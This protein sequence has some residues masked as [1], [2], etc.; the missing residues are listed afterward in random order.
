MKEGCK[1]NEPSAAGDTPDERPAFPFVVQG[2]AVGG[3]SGMTLRE[4]LAGMALASIG[5]GPGADLKYYAKHC[6][7]MADAMLGALEGDGNG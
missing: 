7:A 5:V 3:C 6:V 2:D 4:W 1:P